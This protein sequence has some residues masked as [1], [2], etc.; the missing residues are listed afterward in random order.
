[1]NDPR[2]ATIPDRLATLRG[3]SASSADKVAPECFSLDA[4]LDAMTAAA[5]KGFAFVLVAPP[6]AIDLRATNTWKDTEARLQAMGFTVEA[7][8][9]P[10]Q[11][12]VG[13]SWGML[14]QWLE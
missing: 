3:L 13:M 10:A 6:E 1:M 7:K 14:V 5:N 12:A 11:I 4:V 8:Q 9:L 2:K